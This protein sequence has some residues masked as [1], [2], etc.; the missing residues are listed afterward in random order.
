MD[1]SLNEETLYLKKKRKRREKM[2]E[3]ESFLC[4]RTGFTMVAI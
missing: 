1:N 4:S 2:E 3:G